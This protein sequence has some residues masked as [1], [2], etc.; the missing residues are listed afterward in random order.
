MDREMQEEEAAAKRAPQP[1]PPTGMS[2]DS[3]DDESDDETTPAD[4][5][6]SFGSDS[7]D[8]DDPSLPVV[9]MPV[10]EDTPPARALGWSPWPFSGAVSAANAPPEGGRG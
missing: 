5:G 3:S 8:N 2:M 10:A 9:C 6:D 7:E 1:A 4:G